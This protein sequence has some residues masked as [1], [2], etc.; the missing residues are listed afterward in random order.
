MFWGV[1]GF[2]PLCFSL[3]AD[4]E[5]TFQIDFDVTGDLF[6]GVLAVF[7]EVSSCVDDDVYTMLCEV[8]GDFNQNAVEHVPFL[9]RVGGVWSNSFTEQVGA[10]GLGLNVVLF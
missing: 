3:Y 6:A 5:R 8:F 2:S 9:F 10:K 4:F 7:S 1:E